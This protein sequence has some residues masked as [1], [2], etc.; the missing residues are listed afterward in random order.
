MLSTLTAVLLLLAGIV[1]LLGL[2]IAVV[3]GVRVARTRRAARLIAGPRRALLTLLAD[4]DPEAADHLVALPERTWQ[5]TQPTAVA[6]LGKIR[7]EARDGLLDVF[8]RRGVTATALRDLRRPGRVRRARAAEA[9]GNLGRRE[10]VPR[11]CAMLAGE[12]PEA[13]VVAVRA[14]GRIG[15]PAAAGPLLASLSAAEPTPSQL[16]AHALVQ[17]GPDAVPSL[18]DALRHPDA[19]VRVTALDALGLLGAA[20]GTGVVA[21]VLRDDPDPDVRSAAA[22]TLGRLGAPG[23]LT[24]LLAALAPTEPTALRVA[25]ARALGELGAAAAVEPLGEL[26]HDPQY[27][28]AH[29]AAHALRRLGPAGWAQLRRQAEAPGAGERTGPS[30]AAADATAS[31]ATALDAPGTRQAGPASAAAHAEEALALLAVMEE[32]THPEPTPALAVG[33]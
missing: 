16:V 3:R 11:L 5:A 18:T 28:V 9:L 6:L 4:D 8:E 22:A 33:R 13:R 27:R 32:P 23:G 7:G 19:L 15:D 1:V 20:A 17:L 25:A 26:L 12:D 21:E 30:A 14:L 31:P 24:P 10:A 2:V 29:E